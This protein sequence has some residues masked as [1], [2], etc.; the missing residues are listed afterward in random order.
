MRL[1]SGVPCSTLFL[2]AI[3]PPFC[4]R[5]L[6]LS[7][8]IPR[9]RQAHQL[10]SSC[11]CPSCP[12]C[13][14]TCGAKI[15]YLPR[16]HVLW[17]PPPP[18]FFVAPVQNRECVP[19]YDFFPPLSVVFA[20]GRAGKLQTL[21]WLCFGWYFMLDRSYVQ[22][23]FKG[24]PASTATLYVSTQSASC[25]FSAEFAQ[26]T[27]INVPHVFMAAFCSGRLSHSHPVLGQFS[28]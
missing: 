6:L 24:C 15:P 22:C 16:N 20:C 17:H 2:P 7:P 8:E 21:H 25:M 13:V 12:T 11:T 10:P 5:Y 18:F 1:L 23:W 14:Q 19:I 3:S 4:W 27:A 26:Q 28:N 9:H